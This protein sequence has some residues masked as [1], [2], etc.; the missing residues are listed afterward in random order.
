MNLDESCVV[1]KQGVKLKVR[2]IGAANVRTG[3]AAQRIRDDVLFTGLMPYIQL[4]LLKELRRPDKTEVHPYGG[5]CRGNRGLLED[6]QNC[7][8]VGL[9]NDAGLRGLNQVSDF[10]N[11]PNEARDLELCR[12]VILFSGGEESRKKKNWFD[13]GAARLTALRQILTGGYVKDHRSESKLLGGVQVNP[14]G[15]VGVVMHEN[16]GLA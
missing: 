12:P 13:Q 8:V 9:D 5:S 4:E 1:C 3:Q 7:R 2:R 16:R 11:H 14:Q 15:L 10:F 6:I